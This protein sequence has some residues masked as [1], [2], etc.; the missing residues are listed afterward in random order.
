[1][2]NNHASVST[3]LIKVIPFVLLALVAASQFVSASPGAPPDG[4]PLTTITCA[5]VFCAPGFRCEMSGRVPVCVPDADQFCG[6]TTEYV[7]VCGEDGRTYPNVCAARC[8]KVSVAHEG[9]CFDAA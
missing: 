3:R 9:T 8:A 7:P 6:C 2:S 1:M 4:E 5:S